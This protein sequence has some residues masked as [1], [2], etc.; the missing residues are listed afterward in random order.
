MP[1]RTKGPLRGPQSDE[2]HLRK[3][4]TDH[5]NQ[6]LGWVET[7]GLEKNPLVRMA[8]ELDRKFQLR[9]LMLLFLFSLLLS[10]LVYLDFSTPGDFRVGEIVATDVKSPM[11]LQMVDEV[12]TETKR[13]EAEKNLPLILDH[14]RDAFDPVYARIYKAFREQRSRAKAIQW[15][16]SE[17]KRDEVIKDFFQ[18]KSEFTQSLGA[19]VTDPLFEW[20]VRNRFSVRLENVLIAAMSRWSEQIIVDFPDVL[21]D[22]NLNDPERVLLVREVSSGSQKR[23]FSKKRSEVS[24]LKELSTFKLEGLRGF[25]A[26]ERES[27]EN[28]ARLARSLIVANANLNRQEIAERQK[29]ARDAILPMQINIKKNQT[30]VAAGTA[31]KPVHITILDEIRDIRSSQRTEFIILA[32]A[33]LFVLLVAIA[34]GFLRRFSRQGLE[35][36]LKDS[37]VLGSI[38]VFLIALCKGLLFLTETALVERFGSIIPAMAFVFFA[39]VAAGPML[40]SLLLNSAE[41]V[42]IFT[43]FLSFVVA[44]LSEM[45]IMVLIVAIVSGVAAAK[46]VFACESRNDIYWAGLQTGLVQALAIFLV[47]SID[48]IGSENLFVELLWTSGAGFLSGLLAAFVTLMVVPLIESAFRYTTDLK[49]L[50]LSSLNHPLM[51]ELMMKAPGTYHHCMAVGTMVDAAARDIGANPLLAKVMAYYHDIGKMEHAQYFIENQ[52]TGHNPH[53]HI[54]PHMS[55]TILIAHVKDGA[56]MAIKHSLGKPIVDGILQHHGTTLISYFFNRAAE[57]QDEDVTG[58]VEESDFRYPGPKPQFKEAAL[59][60]LADSIEATA[61]SLDEPTPGRL[62]SIVENIIESKLMDGQLDECDLTIKDLAVIK[63][64]F[65]RIIQAIYHQRMQYP[66]MKDGRSIALHDK[67]PQRKRG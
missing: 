16:K 3:K 5:S 10:W 48:R 29:R 30:I 58:A 31:V 33:L 41:V 6:F 22:P 27:Q 43:V 20:L 4:Y 35:I 37:L 9:K 55:K 32:S 62:N 40:A 63:D 52:R 38:T 59:C 12:S 42:W 11:N 49:L 15:P 67:R 2:I 17:L 19:E 50:E 39:P 21:A 53:D 36:S 57:A 14:E 61:R 47:Y 56:E 46:A 60:M 23:E 13:F 7:L 34:T 8:V 26:L 45:N 44:A 1:W 54:S 18:F 65:K 51:R 25:T 28:L 64:S 24:D 66:N